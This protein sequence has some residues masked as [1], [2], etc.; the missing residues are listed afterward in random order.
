MEMKKLALVGLTIAAVA[1]APQ[2]S[3]DVPGIAPFVGSW[4]AHASGLTINGDGSGRLSYADVN[5]CPESCSYADAPVATV[6]F[7]LMSVS[8]GTATGS[9]NAVSNPSNDVVGEPVTITLVTGIGP[10]FTGPPA[11]V[12][13]A[14]GVA[15][16]ASIGKMTDWNFCNDTT[17]NYCGG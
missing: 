3:A 12:S 13:G 2:V 11:S 5:A 9:V 16:Q 14:N 6:D 10:P 1:F 7:T 8:G 15:L 4:Q 17:H